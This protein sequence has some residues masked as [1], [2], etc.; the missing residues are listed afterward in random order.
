LW[1]CSRTSFPDDKSAKEFHNSELLS[2]HLSK[3]GVLR[4]PINNKHTSKG[5]FHVADYGL[6]IPAVKISVPLISFT[7]LLKKSFEPADNLNVLPYT[8]NWRTPVVTMVL[9]QL[10]P[11]ACPEIPGQSAEKFLEVISLCQVHALQNW[12]LW[13]LFFGNAGDP[14][15]PEND[16]GLDTSHWTGTSGCSIAAPHLRKC[17]KK[18]LGLPHVSEAT[19]KQKGKCWEKNDKLYNNGKPFKI[20]LC[21]KRGIMVTILVDNYFIE[22]E[23]IFYGIVCYCFA[24][25]TEIIKI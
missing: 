5:V 4:N 18:E 24:F 11:L 17:L 14:N 15:L 23:A 1:S 21:N 2:Y 7:R 19:K 22:F 10:R 8:S 20:D 3:G 9:L 6:P 25:H 12:I 13:S 16:V